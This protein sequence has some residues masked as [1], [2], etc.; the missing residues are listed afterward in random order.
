[1]TFICYSNRFFVVVILT[2]QSI[3]FK[4]ICAKEPAAYNNVHKAFKGKRGNPLF[5]RMFI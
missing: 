3:N 2:V 5:T 4:I 1:M